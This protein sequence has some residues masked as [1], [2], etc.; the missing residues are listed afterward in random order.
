MKLEKFVFHPS[1]AWGSMSHGMEET[2]QLS[3]DLLTS[4]EEY[5]GTYPNRSMPTPPPAFRESQGTHI[6][7]S[8]IINPDLQKTL[9]L[10]KNPKRQCSCKSPDRQQ[11]TKLN[12]LLFIGPRFCHTEGQD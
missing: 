12:F 3:A 7:F 1:S 6:K 9:T 11:L 2:T 5:T 10:K 8:G 4:S